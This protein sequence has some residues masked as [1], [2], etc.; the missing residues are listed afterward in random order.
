LK[1][2]HQLLIIEDDEE[3]SNYVSSVV[4]KR[5]RSLPNGEAGFNMA[6]EIIPDLI[7]CM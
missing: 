2:V 1:Q 3:M 7:I 5:S 6:I 4:I